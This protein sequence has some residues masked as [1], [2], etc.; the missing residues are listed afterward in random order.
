ME[1]HMPNVE[2]HDDVGRDSFVVILETIPDAKS[3]A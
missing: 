3:K 1:R 2:G